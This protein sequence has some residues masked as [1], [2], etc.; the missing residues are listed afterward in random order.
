MSL[1]Y[2]LARTADSVSDG[3]W[4][5]AE[6]RAAALSDF[7]ESLH[8]PTALPRWQARIETVASDS[9]AEAALLHHLPQALSELAALPPEDQRLIRGI[10][11]TLA[12][13]MKVDLDRFPGSVESAAE[14]DN[15]LWYAAGCVGEFW[16][17]VLRR[18]VAGLAELPDSLERQ[19][20]ELG[21]A[22]QITNVLR[23]IPGDLRDG[24]CYLPAEELREVGLQPADLSDP[25]VEPR[26]G[27]VFYRWMGVGLA[28]YR[29]SLD[30][31][32]TLPAREW[33]ARLA[34]MW[35]W[36]MGLATLEQLTRPGW[37][38]EKRKVKRSWVYRMILQTVPLSPFTP[39]LRAY[40]ERAWKQTQ[41]AWLRA[42]EL[43]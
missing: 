43:T 29:T 2:L 19:G 12:Q 27:P 23:D 39:W 22:L 15:H 31:I 30:Y 24:R 10:V 11:D 14:L 18:H 13:G 4:L 5:P 8:D 35:P 40:L 3:E 1:A 21:K 7:R 9:G 26:V 41:R 25:L 38:R 32:L 33:R 28:H 42:Q 6:Q 20:T 17:A 34:A 37:L 36:L 16:T